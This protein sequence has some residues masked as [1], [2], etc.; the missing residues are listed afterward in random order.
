MKVKWAE[1]E[2]SLTH[3]YALS[4]LLPP[5]ETGDDHNHALLTVA[6]SPIRR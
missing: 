4:R 2:S 6:C 3:L 5:A 1:R